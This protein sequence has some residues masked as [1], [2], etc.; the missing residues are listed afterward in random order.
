[1]KHS[2]MNESYDISFGIGTSM[3]IAQQRKLKLKAALESSLSYFTFT[4]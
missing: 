4:R 2:A 1:M 3:A